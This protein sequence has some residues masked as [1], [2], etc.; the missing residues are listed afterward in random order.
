M[1]RLP[2]VAALL[3][4]SACGDS[5]TTAPPPDIPPTEA[6]SAEPSAETFDEPPPA[7]ETA[8]VEISPVGDLME[9]EQTAFAVRP[10][11]TVRLAFVNT[12]TS[13]AMHHNVVVLALNTD[14]DAFGQAAMMA[15]DTDYVPAD[16]ADEVVAHTPM[17]APGETVEVTFTAPVAPGDYTYV[18]TFPGHY[19]TMRGTMR[20]VEA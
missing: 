4:F 19:I 12:A 5:D 16:R 10:G 13:E 8:E 20:I 11:Q 17:S 15:A 18:C 9:Y 6:P 1:S 3:V 7:G 14:A 2:L